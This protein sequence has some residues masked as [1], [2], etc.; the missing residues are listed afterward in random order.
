M[1]LNNGDVVAISDEDRI[2]VF[3][4]FDRAVARAEKHPLC[5]A[6]PYQIVELDEL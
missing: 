3:S 4:D 2:T 1:R 5:Q 6:V